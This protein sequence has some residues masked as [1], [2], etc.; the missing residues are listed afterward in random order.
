MANKPFQITKLERMQAFPQ[1]SRGLPS[2]VFYGECAQSDPL[3]PCDIDNC[4]IG[5]FGRLS[6]LASRK[7]LQAIFGLPDRKSFEDHVQVCEGVLSFVA[8]CCS[9]D[10]HCGIVLSHPSLR[11]EERTALPSVRLPPVSYTHLTLPTKLEV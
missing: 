2:E 4:W 6:S 3:M 1:C 11:V 9:E 8:R 10:L 5:N 7:G